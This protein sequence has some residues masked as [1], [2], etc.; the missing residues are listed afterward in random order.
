MTPFL[1]FAR[2]GARARGALALCVAAALFGTLAAAAQA[3]FPAAN[4]KIT[5]SSGLAS[6]ESLV[7]KVRVIISEQ[8][9]IGAFGKFVL[10]GPAGSDSG[11]T[12]LSPREEA[13]GLRDGQ[14]YILV[15]GSDSLKGKKG[16]LLFSWSGTHVNAAANRIVE[17]GTWHIAAGGAGTGMYK[18]WT[19]GGRRGLF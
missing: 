16:T 15:N 7:S 10:T 5:G 19:G 1:Y 11:S 6:R 13:A 18:S 4:G 3:T 2:T 12:T 8:G 17:Y 14:H 9:D